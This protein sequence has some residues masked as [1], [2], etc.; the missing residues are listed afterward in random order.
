M[1]R[2]GV[3]VLDWPAQSPDLND[4]EHLLDELEQRP[5]VPDFTNALLEE[6]SKIPVNILLHHVERSLCRRVYATVWLM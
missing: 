2:F 1:S 4:K 3:D 6:W 5:E